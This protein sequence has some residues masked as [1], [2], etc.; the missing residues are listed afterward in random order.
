MRLAHALHA[1]GGDDVA[2]AGTDLLR[3]ERH[4][5]KAG[6]ADLVDAEGGLAIR[7][8][9]GAGG[10]AGGVLALAGGQHLAE[11][12]LIHVAR[13]EPGALHGGVQGGRAEHMGGDRA[14]GAV[15]AADR[16]T[17]G[18]D[19]DDVVHFWLSRAGPLGRVGE[20]IG[21]KVGAKPPGESTCPGMAAIGF[22]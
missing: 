3:R 20:K 4:G 13:L 2:L 5:A 10:L 11:D 9:G 7:Q 6:A 1:A 12:D 15:E 21:G 17:G 8:A 14:E 16:R 18:G 22:A 19:D